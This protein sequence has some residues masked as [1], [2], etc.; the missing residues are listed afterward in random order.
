LK[1]LLITAHRT[2]IDLTALFRIVVSF[3]LNVA[4]YLILARYLQFPK[5]QKRIANFR[6]NL[7][8]EYLIFFQKLFFY[9]FR[10]LS[11]EENGKIHM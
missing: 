1:A 7:I 10:Y 3:L 5:Y 9:R 8:D 6:I 2:P 11:F 4:E